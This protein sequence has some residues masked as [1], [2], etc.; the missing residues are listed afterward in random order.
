VRKRKLD[1]FRIEAR[2]PCDSCGGTGEVEFLN[3]EGEEETALCGECLGQS[4]RAD[5]E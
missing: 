2:L 1:E 3:D 5:P 4:R